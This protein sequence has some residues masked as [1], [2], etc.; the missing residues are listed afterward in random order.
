MSFQGT[1][2]LNYGKGVIAVQNTIHNQFHLKRHRQ[3]DFVVFWS[4]LLEYSTKDL[5]LGGIKK[6]Q[7]QTLYTARARALSKGAAWQ[8]FPFPS[9]KRGKHERRARALHNKKKKNAVNALVRL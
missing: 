6:L 7:F 3:R 9:A 4:K 8:S 5:F 1:L 2:N